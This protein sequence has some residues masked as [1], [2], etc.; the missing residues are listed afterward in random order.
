M[1]KRCKVSDV[2]AEA[3]QAK[4]KDKEQQ[5]ANWLEAQHSFEERQARLKAAAQAEAAAEAERAAWYSS[6]A[7]IAATQR[8]RERLNAYHAGNTPANR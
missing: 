1:A 7:G 4:L 6:P 3:E 8:A 2:E 5:R